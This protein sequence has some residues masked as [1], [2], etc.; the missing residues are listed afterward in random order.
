MRTRTRKAR[1][2]ISMQN[3][4]ALEHVSTQDTLACDHVSTQSTLTRARKARNLAD[5][6]II[7]LKLMM[8]VALIHT[9]VPYIGK[10]NHIKNT[11]T[12]IFESLPSV[13]TVMMVQ[14][15]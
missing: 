12:I 9:I 15:Q 8:V 2:H 4:L 14:L 1:E 7:I 11:V 10:N 5:L 6:K 3:T 13:L